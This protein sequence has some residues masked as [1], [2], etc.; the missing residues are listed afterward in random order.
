MHNNRWKVVVASVDVD[1]GKDVDTVY[2]LTID[3]LWLNQVM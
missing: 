3:H 1:V 2:H